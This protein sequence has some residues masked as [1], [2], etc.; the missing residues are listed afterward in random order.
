MK[1]NRLWYSTPANDWN[2][3]LPLGNG[4]LGMMVFG[5]TSEE[6]IQLNEETMWSG[7]EY[8][9]F[10]SP[11]TLEHLDEM[12]QLIFEGKYTEAQDLSNRYMIC[13]GNG[14]HDVTG[15][16]G[17]YQTAGDLYITF[18]QENPDA[19]DYHRELRLDEGRA[20]VSYDGV[21]RDY[22]VSA[23]TTLP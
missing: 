16:Y 14:H 23:I 19:S 3:A 1:E 18:A 17:S 7:W 4:K 21:K 20:E 15:A 9:E 2:E 11:K 5:G 13:R 10:D 8:P 6:R 12:R 22:F